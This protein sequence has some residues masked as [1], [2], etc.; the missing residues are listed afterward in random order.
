MSS[1]LSELAPGLVGLWLLPFPGA[2]VLSLG[3]PLGLPLPL[4]APLSLPLPLCLPWFW[5]G[6]LEA[7]S[8]THSPM[9]CT[10]RRP[11][12]P[13]QASTCVVP[14]WPQFVAFHLP[15]T[16]PPV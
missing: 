1:E 5:R 15:L 2:L 4:S 12:D 14:L 10:P 9:P 6:L 16:P 8:L 11:A 3:V 7:K 13:L